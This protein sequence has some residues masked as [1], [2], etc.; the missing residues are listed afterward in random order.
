MAKWDFRAQK[1]KLKGLKRKLPRAIAV[2]AK[3]HYKNS[4]R[5]QGFTNKSLKAW[6][7]RSPDKDPGRAVLVKTG[8][9]RDSIDIRRDKFNDIRVGTDNPYATYHN[10]GQGQKKRQFIGESAVLTT[11]VV[12]L[13]NAQI[14]KVFA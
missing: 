12:R 7:K 1:I 14:K 6:A 13:I 3:S 9:L 4:F 10:K 8:R 2:L 5:R 11:K